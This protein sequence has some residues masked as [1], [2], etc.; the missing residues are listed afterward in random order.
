MDNKDRNVLDRFLDNYEKQNE[1]NIVYKKVYEKPS[2]GKTIIGFIFSLGFFIILIR[3]F[4][5]K[6]FYFFFLIGDILVLIYYSLNLFTKKG[7]ALPKTLAIKEEK[8]DKSD[9]GDDSN[10]YRN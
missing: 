6:P 8:D 4:L 1:S 10:E 9:E 7:F 3:H 5:L 2:K